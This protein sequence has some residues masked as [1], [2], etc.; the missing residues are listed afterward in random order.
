MT[1]PTPSPALPSSPRERM[2][3][4]LRKLLRGPDAERAVAIILHDADAYA[5]QM[6]EE[7][8]RPDDRWGPK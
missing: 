7:I 4:R 6:A 8:A 3:A 2:E 5:A 1:I